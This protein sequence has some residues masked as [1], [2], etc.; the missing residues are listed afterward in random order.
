MP[1]N[2][3]AGAV[4]SLGVRIAMCTP[5]DGSNVELMSPADPGAPLNASLQKFID[6]RGEGPLRAHA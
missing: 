5:G 4:E 1:V 6:R 2:E 3:V